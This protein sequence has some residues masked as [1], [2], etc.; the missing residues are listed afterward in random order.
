M[1]RLLG[2]RDLS[3]AKTEAERAEGSL[4]RAAEHLD[5]IAEARRA[6]KPTPEAERDK[7]ADAVGEARALAQEIADD[8][9]KLQP[10]ASEMMT[11]QDREAARAQAERQAAIGKRTDDVAGGGRAQAARD[12]GDGEGGGRAQGAGQRMRQASE[13]CARTTRRAP[14]PPSATPPTAWPSC[15]IRCRIARWATAARR[16]RSASP[17]PTNRARRAPGAR[18]CSTR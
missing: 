1:R 12:A 17:A 2:E 4:E 16:T 13:S 10:R 15:G 5:E 6:R 14:P 18:S 11:P 9:D 8:L 7:R 3:E